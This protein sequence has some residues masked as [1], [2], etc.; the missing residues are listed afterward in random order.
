MPEI[1]KLPYDTE[2]RCKVCHPAD[3][4]EPPF[5]QVRM[6]RAH[7]SGNIHRTLEC[8]NCGF[9]DSDLWNPVL[10]T[11]VFNRELDEA[12]SRGKPIPPGQH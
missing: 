12:A 6:E 1:K 5:I 2:I 7:P 3:Q 8:P 11:V 10:K 4:D 9:T